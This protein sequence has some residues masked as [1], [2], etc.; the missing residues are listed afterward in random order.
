[1]ETQALVRLNTHMFFPMVPKTLFPIRIS[2]IL[3]L[4]ISLAIHASFQE[5]EGM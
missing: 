5:I 1:M 4:V 3:N 2:G